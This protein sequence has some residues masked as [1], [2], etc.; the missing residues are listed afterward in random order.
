MGE[1]GSGKKK[2]AGEKQEKKEKG[3]RGAKKN[4]LGLKGKRRLQ[5][6]ETKK[7]RSST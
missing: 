2:K 3:A 1:R 6:K 7:K 4:T 5:G